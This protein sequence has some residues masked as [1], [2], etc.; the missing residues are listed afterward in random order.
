M[1]LKYLWPYARTGLLIGMAILLAMQW[2]D[3]ADHRI[4]TEMTVWLIA[5]VIYGVSSML[6]SVERLSLLAATV[7]HFLLAYVVTVLCCFYLGYGATL[8]QAALDCLPLFVILYAL[9][10]VGTSISIRIQMKRIN[11]KLQK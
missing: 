6:F 3:P 10:Y 5:S 7:L 11:Q 9:I 4:A 2:I 8:T 1:K